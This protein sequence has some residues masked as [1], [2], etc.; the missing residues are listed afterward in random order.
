[1]AWVAVDNFDSYTDGDLATQNGGTGW[2]AAWGGST[3]Y[4]IQGTV[5]YQGAKAVVNSTN[6]NANTDSRALT[7]TTTSGVFYVAMRKGVNNAGVWAVKLASSTGATLTRRFAIVFNASGNIV[8]EG[9][10]NVTLLAGYSANT[11]YVFRIT[12]DTVANTAT[13]AVNT[14]AYQS[15]TAWGTESSAVTGAN[16]GAIAGLYLSKD[17]ATGSDYVD[18]ITGTDPI[19]SPFV[20]KITIL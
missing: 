19:A 17:A 20:P 7:S 1:M 14:G 5:T 13:A 15:G 12:F 8:L 4:D 9:T 16:S 18:I 11:W 6:A 2:S 3:N 10:T